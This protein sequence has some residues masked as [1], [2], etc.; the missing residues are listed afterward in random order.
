MS[1]CAC[2]LVSMVSFEEAVTVV[3][4]AIAM[5]ILVIGVS[6][7]SVIFDYMWSRW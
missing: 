5:L 6:I 1:M 7:R 2:R 4:M 3:S